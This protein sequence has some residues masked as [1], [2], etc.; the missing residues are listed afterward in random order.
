MSTAD[1]GCGPRY[2]RL[3]ADSP[4]IQLIMD[5]GTGRIVESNRAAS[6]FYGYAAAELNNRT[7]FDLS[8]A[9]PETIFQ[10]L[11]AVAAAGSG[12]FSIKHRL[13]TGEIRDMDVYAGA[14]DLDGERLIHSAMIDSTDR[15][16]MEEKLRQSEQKLRDFALAVPTISFIFDEDGRCIEVFARPDALPDRS[17]DEAAEL[18]LYQLFSG[19]VADTF[20]HEIRQT[21]AAGKSRYRVIEF[22]Y[23][24]EKRVF[25]TRTAPMVYLTGGKRTV[26]VVCTDVTERRQAGRQFQ[27][28][29]ELRRRSDIFN[30]LISGRASLDKQALEAGKILGVD[31]SAPLFCCLA[32]IEY[33]VAPD[34]KSSLDQQIL[35]NAIIDAIETGMGFGWDYDGN[36]GLVCQAAD[37]RDNWELGMQTAARLKEIVLRK[38]PDLTVAIGVSESHIGQ[39]ALRKA[40]RQA[41]IAA[42]VAYSDEQTKGQIS[43]FRNLGIFQL[44]ADIHGQEQAQAFVHDKLGSLIQYDKEKG[45]TFLL[46]LEQILQCANLKEAAEKMFLHH[47]TLVFRKQRIEKILGYPVDQFETRLALAAAIKL[48]KLAA[49]Q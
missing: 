3:F 9:S 48:Y 45:T 32:S 46:T 19:D 39:E 21:I 14:V 15:R 1:A 41:W 36:I 27:L 6:A 13:Q 42:S 26:A 17:G 44:L 25:E 49:R 18:T 20:L 34:G 30:D 33:P 10:N 5:P 2:R 31:L 11:K 7:I 24:Q 8:T 43:H 37:A 12:V 28:A 35:R 38:G 47:K 29:Y 23:K 22:V 16:Q 4:I 40:C